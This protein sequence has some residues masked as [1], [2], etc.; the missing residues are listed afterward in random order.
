MYVGEEFVLI[1]GGMS[2]TSHGLTD[3]Y[4]LNTT[5]WRLKKVMHFSCNAGIDVQVIGEQS[6]PTYLY[7]WRNFSIYMYL[8]MHFGPDIAPALRANVTGLAS[9]ACHQCVAFN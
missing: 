7:S 4:S 8:T 6:E 9:S 3:I 2:T 5:T 1:V